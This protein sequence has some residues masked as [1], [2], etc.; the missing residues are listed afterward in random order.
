VGGAGEGLINSNF[1]LIGE[2]RESREKGM[3]PGRDGIFI[4]FFMNSTD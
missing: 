4:T 3:K 2:I 1:V